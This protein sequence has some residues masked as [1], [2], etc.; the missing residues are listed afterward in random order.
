MGTKVIPALWEAQAGG[1]LET[2]SQWNFFCGG[3]GGGVECCSV[4]Q[5]G[6]QWHNL[7]SLKP[8][9][10]GFKQ[11][12]FLSLL[13]SWNY[14]HAQ[15]CPANFCIFS[16]DGVSTCWSGW[17]QNPDLRWST[18]L[19]LPNCWDYRHELPPRPA[20]PILKLPPMHTC[21]LLLCFIF[22]LDQPLTYSIIC[23]FV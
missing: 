16:R 13:S 21:Y 12:S 1:L 2:R 17:F 7:G 22:S 11:F 5:A 19:S 3:V 4:A 20:L 6:V 14:R 23:L 15:S 9:P 18:C 10:P 8:P